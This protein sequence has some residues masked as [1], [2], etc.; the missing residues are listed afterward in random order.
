[1]PGLINKIEVLSH[2]KQLDSVGQ[3]IAKITGTLNKPRSDKIKAL[4]VLD[5]KNGE[6]F[7]EVNILMNYKSTLLKQILIYH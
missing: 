3:E 7:G 6:T 2:A 4:D 5:H 1:M